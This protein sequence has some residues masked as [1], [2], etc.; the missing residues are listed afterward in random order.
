MKKNV[1]TYVYLVLS[2]TLISGCGSSNSSDVGNPN[3]PNNNQETQVFN[4]LS[5]TEMAKVLSA[6]EEMEAVNIFSSAYQEENKSKIKKIQN[7]EDIFEITDDLYVMKEFPEV[8][9]Q[10]MYVDNRVGGI[11]LETETTLG[12]CF[13]SMG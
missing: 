6:K 13:F 1:L 10:T 11:K 5:K 4:N 7:N 9:N 3:N 2:V 12:W 8:S